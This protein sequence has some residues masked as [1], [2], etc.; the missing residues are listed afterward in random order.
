MPTIY[1]RRTY[2]NYR[3]GLQLLHH[4]GGAAGAVAIAGNHDVQAIK[5]LAA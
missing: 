3:N 4:L 1:S 5:G 2:I